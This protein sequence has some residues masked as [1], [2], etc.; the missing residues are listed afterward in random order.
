MNNV[1]SL[2]EKREEKTINING[3][4]V[5]VEDYNEVGEEVEGSSD[6]VTGHEENIFVNDLIKNLAKEGNL[7]KN[8]IQEFRRDFKAYI[9]NDDKLMEEMDRLQAEYQ[10]IMDESN[11]EF[12][13]LIKEL[14]NGEVVRKLEVMRDTAIRINKKD[15]AEHYSIMIEDLKS[16]VS[17]DY[18]FK[19]L[20]SIKNKAKLLPRMKETYDREYGKFFKLLETNTRFLF[21]N[22]NKLEETLVNEMGWSN[23]DARLV[24]LSIFKFVNIKPSRLDKHAI[25]IERITKNIYILASDEDPAGI[26]DEFKANLNRLLAMH[27]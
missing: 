25:F 14:T 26:R 5:D 11:E 4:D 24:L 27:Y 18:L 10:A 7:T 12:D 23:D 21:P 2:D 19:T 9:E 13:N 6:E 20:S 17:L 16:S 15:L 1:I 22:P 8:M 3:I